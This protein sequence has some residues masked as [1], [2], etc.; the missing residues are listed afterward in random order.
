MELEEFCTENAISYSCQFNHVNGW[1][2]YTFR[3]RNQNHTIQISI[4]DLLDRKECDDILIRK[5]YDSGL[6]DVE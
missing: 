6:L 5:I 1:I 2:S 3:T 4:N